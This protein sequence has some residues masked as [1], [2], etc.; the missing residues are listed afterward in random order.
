MAE[1]KAVARRKSGLGRGLDALMGDVAL[2]PVRS[3]AGGTE[4]VDENAAGQVRTIAIADIRPHPQQPRRHF[5]EEA[6][7]ELAASIAERGIIQPILVRPHGKGYQIVAGER[8]WRAAQRARLQEVPAIVRE[9]SESE[10]LEI[11]LI[12]NIQREEL[13]AIEEAEAYQRLAT[14]FGHSQAEIARL[15]DKSRSHVANLMRLLELPAPVRA[16]VVGKQ[17]SMGHARALVNHEEAEQLA[18]RAVDQQLSVRQLEQLVRKSR[19]GK[20]EGADNEGAGKGRSPSARKAAAEKNT[21]LK[22]L[23]LHLGEMLGLAVSIDTVGE[24][25]EGTVTL[26][27]ASLDQLDMICQR[28][29]GEHF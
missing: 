17:L 23:E 2:S 22:A 14:D 8:R 27:F 12:E 4:V 21:D 29:T 16:M 25:N 9:L 10:T 3:V 15:V 1:D 11:A 20:G 26:S 19:D 18:L 5:T 13:N 24:G 7:D 28:L 6:L